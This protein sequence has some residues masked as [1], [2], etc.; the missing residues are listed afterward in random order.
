M[1]ITLIVR[2]R[3]RGIERAVVMTT[4]NGFRVHNILGCVGVRPEAGGGRVG[5]ERQPSLK[6]YFQF[7]RTPSI[8]ALLFPSM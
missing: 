2:L 5:R 6:L 8:P 7:G 3:S 4:D 1:T